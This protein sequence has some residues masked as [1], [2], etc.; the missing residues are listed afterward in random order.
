MAVLG[1]WYILNRFRQLRPLFEVEG[2]L[3]TFDG[4]AGRDM[5]EAIL[6]Q[7][8][9]SGYRDYWQRHRTGMTGEMKEAAG[10]IES[11]GYM[12]WR[13]GWREAHAHDMLGLGP[14]HAL[15]AV[16]TFG[17]LIDRMKKD[18]R[19][20]EV[21]KERLARWE[22]EKKAAGYRDKLRALGVEPDGWLAPPP[23]P[24]E[25]SPSATPTPV[26]PTE[27]APGAAD[28]QLRG[29]A[30]ARGRPMRLL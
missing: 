3:P 20:A 7:T 25:Q 1:A 23:D 18:D 8:R 24:Q 17:M 30:S 14:Q 19:E 16:D 11:M 29:R 28:D 21:Q 13:S 22:A 27:P 4:E 15:S 2:E 10:A 5:L 9:A 6:I 12:A 26:P